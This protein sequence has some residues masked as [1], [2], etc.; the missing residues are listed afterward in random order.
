M[1]F[2]RKSLMLQ[3]SLGQLLWSLQCESRDHPER[4]KQFYVNLLCDDDNQHRISERV[5]N[6]VDSFSA[7]IMHAVMKVFKIQPSCEWPLPYTVQLDKNS[8][9]HF[10]IVLVTVFIPS[11]KPDWNNP[12]SACSTLSKY[13]SWSSA[14]TFYKWLRG[15][16]QSTFIHDFLEEF[17][18]LYICIIGFL[19]FWIYFTETRQLI[20]RM[21][22]IYWK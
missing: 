13:G 18:V 22:S 20:V 11:S 1:L 8:H 16:I 17:H 6:N 15:K 7:D 2:F 4:L 3:T 9:S 10:Y 19:L 14:S 5:K 12:R 21:V